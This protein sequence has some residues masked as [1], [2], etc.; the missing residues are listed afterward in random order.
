MS[1]FIAMNRFRILRGHEAAFVEHWKN[2]ESHLGSVPGFVR[3][4]LLQG[5]QNEE[6][7][8]FASHTEWQSEQHFIDWTHS[9]A[10]RLA[11]ANAGKSPREIYAG[12]PQLE[13]FK[14]VL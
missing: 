11:H 12:P 6:W 13:L 2:R 8:L 3:F 14:A 10:F 5:P 9:E 7:T 4:H 1:T